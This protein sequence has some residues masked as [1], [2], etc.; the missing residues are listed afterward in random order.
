[1]TKGNSITLGSTNIQVSPLGIGTWSWGDRG[2]WQF[3][4]THTEQDVNQVVRTA[5]HSGVNFFDT[6]ESYAGGES[7]KLLGNALRSQ[8]LTAVIATKFSPGRWQ[9]RK[10]DMVKALRK[11]LERLGM[12]QVDLYQ[13]HWPTRFASIESRMDALVACVQEGL[14]K[15]VGVSNFSLDQLHR[16]F[17]ALAKRSI[18]LA[19]IQIEYSL[20]HR[21]P[22]WNGIA[23]ICQKQNI[24]LIAYSPLAMG[25]LTGKY[26][27]DHL[28][29]R[30][31]SEKFSASFLRDIQG[32]IHLMKEIG[33][34]HQ[35][36]TIAQIALNWLLC[37]RAL[38]IPGAKTALQAQ[39]HCGAM[40]WSLTNREIE[41]LDDTSR[42]LQL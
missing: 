4:L 16:A 33:E 38:P 1:M 22:E 39:E 35:G 41:I 40:G 31:R 42:T 19:S 2:D 20:L 17:D 3:G 15:S 14:T 34:A 27:P 28:P 5:L 8:N 18:P 32:L 29:P 30:G 36:K 7:E 11:S 12:E 21:A 24:T 9:I 26:S 25:M 10:R 6:A 23:D 13:L 37:K